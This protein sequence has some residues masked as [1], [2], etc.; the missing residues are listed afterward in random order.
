MSAC[1]GY[2]RLAS[3]CDGSISEPMWRIG[4]GRVKCCVMR[5]MSEVIATHVSDASMTPWSSCETREVFRP[6]CAA[7]DW[8]HGDWGGWNLEV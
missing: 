6:T 3:K 5:C 7:S 1:R 8:R 2:A 4:S